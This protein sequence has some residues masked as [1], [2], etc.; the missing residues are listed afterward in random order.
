VALFERA[1]D[2]AVAD[3]AADYDVAAVA[4]TTQLYSRI[5]ET[6]TGRVV[7][8]WNGPW[9]AAG[10]PGAATAWAE[11]SGCPPSLLYPVYR[12]ATLDDAGRARFRPFGLKEHLIERLTGRLVTDY[13]TASASGL[14]DRR[15]GTWNHG[16]LAG[17]GWTPSDLPEVVAHDAPVGEAAGAVVCPGL[18]DG[19]SASLACRSLSPF[20]GNLGTSTAARVICPAGAGPVDPSLWA[21]AFDA[22]DWVVGGI[23]TRGCG[24]LEGTAGTGPAVRE[25]AFRVAAIVDRLRP[26]SGPAPLVLAGGG[27]H[28]AGLLELIAGSA[29]TDLVLVAE[30]DH[31]A[32]LGA[33]RSA[34]AALGGTP[35][36]VVTVAR[37][38]AP[39]GRWAGGYA[40]WQEAR[41]APAAQEGGPG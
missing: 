41:T 14:F 10:A 40:A 24:E 32:A 22:S 12:L 37:S 21:F 8:P 9:P 39:T 2:R 20:C 29:G 25:V 3:V 18:G 11:V 31:L 30:A 6:T 27:T 26:L 13:T 7:H 23:S 33:V 17:W 16:L 28:H 4:V 15:R 5:E 19:P 34:V 36:D 38:L 35:A 1:V